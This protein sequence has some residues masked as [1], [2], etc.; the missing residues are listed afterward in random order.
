M[1]RHAAAAKAK[2]DSA[3]LAKQAFIAIGQ[4]DW[5]PA[6]GKLVLKLDFYPPSRRH[7][8]DDNLIAQMKPHRDGIAAALETND[9]RFITRADI[10]EPVKGGKVVVTIQPVEE[11]RYG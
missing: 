5:L 9:R 10:K 11:L 1:A 3:W 4:H 6:E 2:Q 7:Y 8:D